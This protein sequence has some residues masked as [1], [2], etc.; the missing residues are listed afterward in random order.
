LNNISLITP[1]DTL[2]NDVYSILLI[3]PSVDR[4]H[5]LNQVLG[6]S[7]LYLNLYLYDSEFDNVGWLINLIKKVDMVI[8][9]VDNCDTKVRPFISYFIAQPNTFYLTNDGTLLYN[10]ISNNRIY[11][12]VMLENIIRGTNE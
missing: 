11:D 8:V 3:C 1:P 10:L 9:D 5:Q 4:K 6:E 12:F 2:N 7:T